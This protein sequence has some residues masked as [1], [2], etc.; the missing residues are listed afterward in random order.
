MNSLFLKGRLTRDPEQ[1]QTE[2]GTVAYFQLAV[3]RPIKSGGEKTSDFPLIT[4]FGKTAENVLKYT[5][6]GLRVIVEG[7]IRTNRYEKNGELHYSI[8]IIGNRVE[9]IDWKEETAAPAASVQAA[10]MST[11]TSDE[12][13]PEDSFDAD[14]D[15]DF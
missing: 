7:R 5:G 8:D 9:F 15:E 10:P 12:A 11:L 2:K 14:M 1:R 13:A 4:V 3:D 6:K